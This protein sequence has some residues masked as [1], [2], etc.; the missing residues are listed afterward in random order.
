MGKL[1]RWVNRYVAFF[2][3]AILGTEAFIKTHKRNPKKAMLRAFYIITLPTLLNYVLNRDNEDY[4][5][6]PSYQRL[7]FWNIPLTAFGLP[8]DVG[9]FN[10]LSL[11]KPFLWGLTYGSLVESAIQWLDKR[12]PAAFMGVASSIL[13]SS[14]PSVTPDLAS[15]LIEWYANRN[16]F[17]G[18]KV[19]SDQLARSTPT[20][21]QYYAETGLTSIA[22][23][24]LLS[25]LNIRFPPA[26]IEHLIFGYAPGLGQ[27]TSFLIDQLLG[28]GSPV[29][30]YPGV[31]TLL[32]QTNQKQTK[33]TQV[34]YQRYGELKE[35][36]K[37][38]EYYRKRGEENPKAEIT[39]SEE[40]E[41]AVLKR[42]NAAIGKNNK[43][44]ERIELNK[45]LSKDDKSKH[46]KQYQQK[47]VQLFRDGREWI[48]KYR[49]QR[50]Q[51]Q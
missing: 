37:E 51:N 1:S 8:R 46:L 6:L 3:P 41:L 4:D 45:T 22:I 5:D 29:S 19:V 16:L 10:F 7:L 9:G 43:I 23:S 20:E 36:A 31:K 27:H 13:D 17:H 12:D 39:R 15:P 33:S 18:G 35:K 42:I 49:K 34:F 40:R 11:P 47:R 2:N 38:K 48:R 21:K 44:L 28:K 32:R 14:I 50:T 25:K 26:K 30:S 24:D